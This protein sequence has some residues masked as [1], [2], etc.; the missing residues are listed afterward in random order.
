MPKA[1]LTLP[2][3]THV[4]V[5]GTTEEV[6]SLLGYYSANRGGAAR[7]S[8]SVVPPRTGAAS[9]GR[10]PGSGQPQRDVSRL[11]SLTKTCPE[12]DKIETQVLDKTSALNRTLLALYI[13]HEHAKT[14][15]GLTSGD[16]AKFTKDL[17]I[18][19]STSNASTILSSSVARPYVIGDKVRRRGVPVRYELS[20]KGAQHMK[21]VIAGG[22]GRLA[23][24]TGDLGRLA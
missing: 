5:D 10:A 6:Q 2:D 3:G 23:H 22:D 16:I 13:V 1:N 8:K 4:T 11:V 9:S 20:R 24:H 17:G 12:A 14:S 15:S 21:T 18:P 7:R 19:I